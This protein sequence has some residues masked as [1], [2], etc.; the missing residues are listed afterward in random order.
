MSATDSP[1][2][3]ATS[4][5]PQT[6][7]A[8]AER[9]CPAGLLALCA[10][11]VAWLFIALLLGLID[12]LKFHDPGFLAGSPYLSYGRVHA[13]QGTAL[14]Y[15]FAVPASLG[16]GLWLICRL[17]RTVLAGRFVVFLGALFWNFAVT[18]AVIA[19]VCGGGRGYDY[20]DLT[21]HC[22][23]LFFIAYLLIGVC[24]M[25]T[26]HQ[27]QP[28]PLYP[29]Q[30]FV[31]GSL[32]WFPW[33]FSTAAMLLLLMPARGTLQS[34]IHWWYVH[35]VDN[36][37]LG[38][39]GLA[40]SFYF[41]PKLLGRPLHSRQ[42]AA[43]AFW[44]IAL[45]GGWG[46][47][48]QGA[49]LP[50][51]IIS[52]GVI[53]TV[54]T[55][56]P[57]LAIFTNFYRTTRGDLKRLDDNLTLRF[58]YI[59]LLFYFVAAAQ[60]IVGVLPNVSAI[61]ALTWFGVAQKQLFHL[62]FFALTMFGALYY[63]IPRLLDVEETAWR[64]KLAKAHFYLTVI[65]IVISYLSLLVCGVGQGVLLVNP[66]HPFAD[67]MRSTLAPLRVSTAGDLLVVVGTILFLLNFALLLTRACFK[68]WADCCVGKEKQPA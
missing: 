51:W 7:R 41:I 11:A 63:I 19:N 24:G 67:V 40:S 26:F 10:G 16:V 50:S 17:G 47:I 31:L 65:G 39:A 3:T 27:R 35:N 46:G 32:F 5:P 60:Q 61:T 23:P 20:F 68:C 2:R 28:G 59:G 9:L 52:L 6:L 14:L 13:A 38:F 42:L 58:S 49:P 53:G 55:A 21:V 57:V 64:P 44:T 25:L 45:F 54:L 36:V 48:P 22:A 43:L 33:I 4:S 1:A 34:A 8:G 56:V 18:V 15:G 37:F 12:S 66:A 30:W 62:G 29:S